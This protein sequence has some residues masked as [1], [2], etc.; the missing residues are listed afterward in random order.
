MTVPNVSLPPQPTLGPPTSSVRP[1]WGKGTSAAVSAVQ[2]TSVNSDKEK[3]DAL[4][5][6]TI[7]RKTG[8]IVDE[9]AQNKDF[10]VRVGLRSGPQ[11]VPTHVL[12]CYGCHGTMVACGVESTEGE[13]R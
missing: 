12:H 6:D 9:L 2:E 10:K 11:V 8:M 1:T 5:E 13:V 4:D 7:C 3:D